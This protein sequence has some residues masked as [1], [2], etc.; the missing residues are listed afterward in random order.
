MGRENNRNEFVPRIDVKV[1]ER[2]IDRQTCK[3]TI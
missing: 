2:L 1:M 3:Y